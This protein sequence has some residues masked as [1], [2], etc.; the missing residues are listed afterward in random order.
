MNDSPLSRKKNLL[1]VKADGAR[2]CPP[3]Q[4]P[5]ALPRGV[6][7]QVA[8]LAR[9]PAE[10]TGERELFCK[11]L[12]E[13]LQ[14]IWEMDRR[15]VSSKPGPAL[16]RAAEAART[17]NEAICSLNKDDREWVERLMARSEYQ[18]LPHE[19][20]RTVSDIDDLF[21]VAIGELKPS[22]PGWAV[23]RNKSGRRKGIVNDATF[24]SVVR[25]LVMWTTVFKGA[26]SFDKNYK[27][28]T[29]IDALNIMRPHLK[30]VIPNALNY[31][32]IQKIK[33]KFFKD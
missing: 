32:T 19:F 8:E 14:E 11:C 10:P 4:T 24:Y 21:S 6:A 15:S 20:L 1:A 16:L 22:V 27:K 23:L 2:P 13:S 3:I 5:P 7:M 31:G 30:G 9:I 29:L 28:G 18:E 17:L 12:S 26:F 25:Y 33:T